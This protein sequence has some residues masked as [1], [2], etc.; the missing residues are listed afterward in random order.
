MILDANLRFDIGDSYWASQTPILSFGSEFLP[1]SNTPINIGLSIGGVDGFKLGYG[2]T[3]KM[4]GLVFDIAF[5]Q[6]GGLF[7]NR[8]GSELGFGLRIEG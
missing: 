1:K 2:L 4:G 6:Q 7:R 8:T 3:I 5:G